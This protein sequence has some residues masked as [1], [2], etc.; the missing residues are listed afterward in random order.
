MLA[1]FFIYQYAMIRRGQSS[2]YLAAF[3]VV[4]IP[5]ALVTLSIDMFI[6]RSLRNKEQKA[7]YIWAIES[8]L[9][10]CCA[11]LLYYFFKSQN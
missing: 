1:G 11:I 2:G 9:L 3:V 4:S 7:G 5:Y 8:V 10:I 6:K